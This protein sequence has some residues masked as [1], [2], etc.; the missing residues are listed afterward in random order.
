MEEVVG[1]L[2]KLRDGAVP[3]NVELL[4]KNGKLLKI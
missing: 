3:S 4:E 1:W 2:R